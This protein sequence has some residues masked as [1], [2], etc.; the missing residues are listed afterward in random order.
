MKILKAI[1]VVVIMLF[2][3]SI[4]YRQG[5]TPIMVDF[6]IERLRQRPAGDARLSLILFFS[7]NNCRSCLKVIDFL[8]KPYERVQVAGIVPEQEMQFINEIRLTTGADFPIY[9]LKKW[10][11]YDPIYAPTLYGVG[12]DG[13]IYFILPCVGLE[14]SYLP[15]F[16]SEFIRKA[17]YLLRSPD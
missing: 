16:L 10:K 4:I 13:N 8:N 6:P 12:P 3:S 15:S 2:L 7:M 11:R 1:L 9:S 5:V 14:E 17:N